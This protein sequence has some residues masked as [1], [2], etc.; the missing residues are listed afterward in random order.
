MKVTFSNG[1]SMDA[2]LAVES[3][4]I[5]RDCITLSIRSKNRIDIEEIYKSIGDG[6]DE[7]SV[8]D[9]TGTTVFK[10]YDTILFI[11]NAMNDESIE[12]SIGLSKS[13]VKKDDDM[14]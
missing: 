9:D 12:G 5:N 4:D 3:H 11:Q 13:M 2:S 14:R 6:L 10:G 7:I 1:Y 8:T